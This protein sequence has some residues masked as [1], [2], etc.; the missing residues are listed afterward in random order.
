MQYILSTARPSSLGLKDFLAQYG[1]IF[2]HSP[3]V[4]ETSWKQGLTTQHDDADVLA[5]SMGAV[6]R[7][8]EIDEQI[9][10]IRAHPDLAGKAALAGELT[11]DSTREQAGAGLDQCTAAEFERFQRMNQAYQDKFGFPFVIA[12]KGLDRHAILNAFEKRLENDA[13]TER[14][15]AINQIIQIARFRLHMRAETAA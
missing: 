11:Q 5:D 10:V 6:L 3:W 4:A 9:A 7:N 1:D 12:V 13:V 14:Q 8:A 15:T 2:E